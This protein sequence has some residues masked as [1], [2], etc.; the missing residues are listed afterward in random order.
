MCY[1]CFSW[2]KPLYTSLNKENDIDD[3][4]NKSLDEIIILTRQFQQLCQNYIH[5]V[6]DYE[7]SNYFKAKKEIDHIN[8]L[9]TSSSTTVNIEGNN[10]V[11]N[12][13]CLYTNTSNYK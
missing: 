8:N 12:Y 10:L 4:N 1:T 6:M 7:T 5:D 3:E 2:L 11:Y 9:L 13:N